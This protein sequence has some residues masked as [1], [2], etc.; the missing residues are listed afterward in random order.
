MDILEVPRPLKPLND[1]MLIAAGPNFVT[2]GARRGRSDQMDLTMS[3][4]DSSRDKERGRIGS[5]Q[6]RIGDRVLTPVRW[7]V[8]LGIVA[9]LFGPL[10]PEV[11]RRG[12][13]AAVAVYALMVAALPHPRSAGTRHARSFTSGAH[14]RSAGTRRLVLAADLLFAA[15]VFHL[16]G[17]IRS[18]Y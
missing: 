14:P 4:S 8:L 11:D 5:Q 6:R 1:R 2:T 3:G 7:M 9:S 13:L 12:L 10:D 18:P 15:A 16:S 17:G